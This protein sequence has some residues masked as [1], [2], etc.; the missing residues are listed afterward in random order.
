MLYFKVANMY[1][2]LGATGLFDTTTSSMFAFLGLSWV[3]YD[4]PSTIGIKAAYMKKAG[5][6]GYVL[7]P[8][9]GDDD[10]LS[11]HRAASNAWK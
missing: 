4:N 9:A 7:W 6:A 8:F 2:P 3:G 1:L 5:A 10:S 11:L